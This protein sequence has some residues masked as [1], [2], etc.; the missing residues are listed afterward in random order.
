MTLKTKPEN[1][2]R[3][4]QALSIVQEGLRSMQ[5]LQAQTAQA[6]QKF[7][8][9]QTEAGR[10]LQEMMKHTQRLAEIAFGHQPALLRRGK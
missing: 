7:L 9:S 4:L 8:E 3:I 1:A 2:D 6:H 5:A 10:T